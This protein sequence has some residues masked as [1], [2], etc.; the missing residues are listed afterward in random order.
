M[1]WFLFLIGKKNVYKRYIRLFL[2][3]HWQKQGHIT[4]PKRGTGKKHGLQRLAKINSDPSLEAGS[5][6]GF[7][8]NKISFHLARE[9]GNQ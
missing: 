5:D 2:T 4:S 3:F 9:K 8:V 6:F 7:Y 1:L